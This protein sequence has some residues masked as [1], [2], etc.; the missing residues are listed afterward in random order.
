VRKLAVVASSGFA[1]MQFFEQNSAFIE[2]PSKNEKYEKE[3]DMKN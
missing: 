3:S 2:I 1:K